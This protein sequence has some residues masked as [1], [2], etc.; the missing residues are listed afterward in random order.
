MIRLS[1]LRS[2]NLPLTSPFAPL[3][4]ID[5]VD[6]IVA[7]L[8]RRLVHRGDGRLFDSTLRLRVCVCLFAGFQLDIIAVALPAVKSG[9]ALGVAGDVLAQAR[10]RV[11]AGFR[12]RSQLARDFVAEEV[13]ER[14]GDRG[15]AGADDA[16]VAFDAAPQSD[17]VVV[18]RRVCVVSDLRQVREAD[19][20][21]GCDEQADEE[22][23]DDAD[24]AASVG[25]LELNEPR[26]RE[27]E[28]DEIQEDVDRAADVGS[29]SEV[30]AGAC[31]FT[32]PLQPKI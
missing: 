1:R 2:S 4:L 31:V 24:L 9:D 20:T 6:I 13:H 30:D 11:R 14:A 16:D 32:I 12:G 7:R 29:E 5:H 19:D 3:V 23:N 18:I 21:A 15:H 26:N 8:L 10:A 22:G 27:E 28:D 25:D 17:V